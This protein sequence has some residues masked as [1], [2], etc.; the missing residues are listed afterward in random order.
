MFEGKVA[1][2][3]VDVEKDIGYRV[4]GRDVVESNGRVEDILSTIV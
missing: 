3:V 1:R 2:G 4:Q